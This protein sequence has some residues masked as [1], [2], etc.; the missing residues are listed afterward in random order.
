MANTDN[1]T[2]ALQVSN[3][4]G[5]YEAYCYDDD[6]MPG[7]LLSRLANNF[8]TPHP[9]S[10]GP[11][12][13]M[14]AVEAGYHGRGISD[15]YVQN[16]RVYTRICRPGDVVLA[17]LQ[18]AAPMLMGIFLMSNGLGAYDG[19]LIAAG[20]TDVGG[21]VAVLLED[22]TEEPNPARRMVQIV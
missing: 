14:F 16:E 21:I 13:K 17:W 11:A 1:N 12:E 7:M 15:A 18:G 6:I 3:N 9:V 8:V 20:G 10:G 22:Y 5:Y 2:I 4:G 19:Y